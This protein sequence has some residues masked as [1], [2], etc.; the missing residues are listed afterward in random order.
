MIVSKLPSAPSAGLSFDAFWR[1]V[2]SVKSRFLRLA[3]FVVDGKDMG[4]IKS[5][6]EENE[7]RKWDECLPLYTL[8]RHSHLCTDQAKL[9]TDQASVVTAHRPCAKLS[10]HFPN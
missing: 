5:S 2:A 6:E 9:C 8:G 7:E 10:S 1:P 3:G 4:E